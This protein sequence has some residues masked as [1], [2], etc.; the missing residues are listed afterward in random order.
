MEV[1]THVQ[2]QHDFIALME[3]VHADHAPLVITSD[4]E[5]SAVLLS[6]EDYNAIEETMYLLRSPQN[7]ARL[8]TA[9]EKGKQGNAVER[10]LFQE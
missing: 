5:P 9:L 7:A 8:L 10:E 2:A 1:I 6:L 3:K 4:G